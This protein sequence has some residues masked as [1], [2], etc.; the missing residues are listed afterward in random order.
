MDLQKLGQLQHK[1]NEVEN[2]IFRLLNQPEEQVNQADRDEF[3]SEFGKWAM[4]VERDPDTTEGEKQYIRG[5]GAAVQELILQLMDEDRRR[6]TEAIL[7]LKRLMD[8]LGIDIGK[9]L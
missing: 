6:G 9:A 4:S 2:D 5:R 1:M 3:L 7:G 8:K